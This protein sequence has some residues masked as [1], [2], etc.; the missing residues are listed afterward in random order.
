MMMLQSTI[1]KAADP[2]LDQI[3]AQ[4]QGHT[5]TIRGT[6]FGGGNYRP[7]FRALELDAP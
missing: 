7:Q 1:A 6:T 5:V 4:L 3:Q 2:T